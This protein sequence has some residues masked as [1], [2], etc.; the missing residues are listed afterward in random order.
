[1]IPAGYMYK[2]IAVTPDW[3]GTDRVRDIYSVSN[4]VSNDF[5]DWINYWKHNGYWFFDNLQAMEDIAKENGIELMDLQPFYYRVHPY[6]WVFESSAWESFALETSFTTAVTEPQHS[7]LEGFDVVTYCVQASAE[8]SPLSCN[9]LAEDLS[10][11]EHC[12]FATFE[13]AK[14]AL[15]SGLFGN[16]EPVPTEYWRSI[17]YDA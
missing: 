2:K 11:N 17:P 15:E 16:T 6:Q 3:L 8:C 5:C 1:M 13:E 7:N 10:V 4:C 9:S 12:L 14:V